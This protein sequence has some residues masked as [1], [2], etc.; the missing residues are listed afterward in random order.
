M[1]QRSVRRRALLRLKCA[2][3]VLVVD[4]LI[5]VGRRALNGNA[6]LALAVAAFAALFFFNTPFPF[7]VIVAGLIGYLAPAPSP[8]QAMARRKAT[9]PHSS[10]SFSRSIRNAQTGLR[11][12]RAA[13]A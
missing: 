6:A 3:L 13:P 1:G 10:T 12:A 4:A 8:P 2:V 7:V 11:R 5:R 9:S